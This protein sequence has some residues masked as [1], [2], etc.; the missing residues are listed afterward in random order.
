MPDPNIQV[1]KDYSNQH[2]NAEVQAYAKLAGASWTYYVRT[3]KVII[4]RQSTESTDEEVHIDLGPSKVVSRRHATIQYNGEYWEISVSGRNGVKIDKNSLRTGNARL[5]SG[6]ILDIGGVQ[7]MFVLPD[8]KPHISLPFKK[9]LEKRFGH[10]YSQSFSGV[11][12][13]ESNNM[14]A[15]NNNNAY[16]L[17]NNAQIPPS[18]AYQ[19]PML[20]ET[21]QQQQQQTQFNQALQPNQIFQPQ[22]SYSQP[23]QEQQFVYQQNVQYAAPN[24]SSFGQT[25]PKPSEQQFQFQQQLSSFSIMQPQPQQSIQNKAQSNQSTLFIN[26][27]G[28]QK[29]TTTTAN[30]PIGSQSTFSVNPPKPPVSS[31]SSNVTIFAQQPQI[32][33]F[34]TGHYFDQDLSNDTA[35]DIKPPFSYATMISQAI[36]STEEHMMSLADIY[37][38]IA[39]KYAFY[40]HSKSGWQNSIRHNLSLNKAFEKVP[41]KVNEPGKGMKWQIV[42]S[43]KEEFCRKALQGDIIKGKST[44]LAKRGKKSASG[45]NKASIS[46]PPATNNAPQSGVLTFQ[47]QAQPVM[48]TNTN[49]ASFQAINPP[50]PIA[51]NN[52]KPIDLSGEQSSSATNDELK[53]SNNQPESKPEIASN[54]EMT[55]SSIDPMFTSE[56][57]APTGTFTEP[58]TFGGK[59]MTPRKFTDSNINTTGFSTPAIGTYSDQYS[60][61][62]MMNDIA[63]A[64]SALASLSTPSPTH[65]FPLLGIGNSGGSNNSNMNSANGSNGNNSLAMGFGSGSNDNLFNFS[66]MGISQLEA[67]TPDRG[68]SSNNTSPNGSNR[69]HTR[70]RSAALTP[71]SK[72]FFDNGN[73]GNGSISGNPDKLKRPSEDENSRTVDA[74][75]QGS[76]DRR[77]PRIHFNSSDP[78]GHSEQFGVSESSANANNDYNRDL[79][80][81]PPP[82]DNEDELKEDGGENSKLKVEAKK[83]VDEKSDTSSPPN[84]NTSSSSS[85]SV[86]STATS[87]SSLEANAETVKGSANLSK[88]EGKEDEND[89]RRK[90][91]KDNDLQSSPTTNNLGS[92]DLVGSL[93]SA[94]SQTPA[95]V[96]SNFQLSAPNSAQQQQL[97]SSFMPAASPAPFWRVLQFASTPLRGSG[98]SGSGPGSA[99]STNG[100]LG[101]F[102]QR[103]TS[104]NSNI[105]SLGQSSS[106]SIPLLG[107]VVS[108]IKGMGSSSPSPLALLPPSSTNSISATNRNLRSNGNSLDSGGD[109]YSPTKPSSL[110]TPTVK[111]G[112]K[113]RTISQLTKPNLNFQPN[114]TSNLSNRESIKDNKDENTEL[115]EKGMVGLGN[116][117]ESPISRKRMSIYHSKEGLKSKANTDK[118]ECLEEEDKKQKNQ[119]KK[120]P[121]E[122]KEEPKTVHDDSNT[123]NNTDDDDDERD[124][125]NSNGSNHNNN[126]NNNNNNDNNSKDDNF[127]GEDSRMDENDDDRNTDSSDK[128]GSKTNT[129]HRS[130]VS[131]ASIKLNNLQLDFLEDDKENQMGSPI[132]PSRVSRRTVSS[133]FALKSSNSLNINAGSQNDF[134]FS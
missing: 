75:S 76:P 119:D 7:M 13:Y 20:Q 105:N 42:Q 55:S 10:S 49:N 24:A 67:Y 26:T 16:T 46:K 15:N 39:T 48:E 62:T 99:G 128:D 81:S 124:N 130:S 66:V 96:P 88:T 27:D 43:Y 58:A 134:S 14:P 68:G 123:K 131:T 12:T 1:A 53:N 70:R 8:S 117:D 118:K 50:Q 45:T 116:G 54:N 84:I 34:G 90:D 87:V 37:D 80:T 47:A 69:G 2:S 35:R 113:I 93:I 31:S 29:T 57:G 30:I 23:P 36:L 79:T 103:P 121:D 25:I 11:P 33:V 111:R 19:T 60:L 77:K 89:D 86:S 106:S 4:G 120:K 110:H 40:R 95:P 126:S 114:S 9:C 132:K 38:W 94:A 44:L 73:N 97:P 18:A 3:L 115:S 52:Q 56:K 41:R 91:E 92:D 63:V 28:E 21:F 125:N 133:S 104:S 127:D 6:N 85:H 82:Y 101:I 5:F 78:S 102:Q 61:S 83:N 109:F 98:S 112:K 65:R 51:E 108:H 72:L 32:R 64:G 74:V 59:L 17:P 100:S 22:Y 122:K 129:S 71:T 107:S